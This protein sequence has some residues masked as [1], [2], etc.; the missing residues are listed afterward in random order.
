MN[1][2]RTATDSS[3]SLPNAG[4]ERQL[5]FAQAPHM[6]RPGSLALSRIF[7]EIAVPSRLKLKAK[8]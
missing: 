7:F 6:E 5:D 4:C 2:Q 8:G 1:L 3:T